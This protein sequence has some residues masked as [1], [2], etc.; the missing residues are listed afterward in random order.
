MIFR[1]HFP[2]SEEKGKKVFGSKNLKSSHLFSFLPPLKEAVASVI[3]TVMSNRISSADVEFFPLDCTSQ[4][5][6]KSKCWFPEDPLSNIFW[7]G[8]QNCEIQKL[9]VSFCPVFCASISETDV[10]LQSQF[11]F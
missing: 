4:E 10:N 7:L 9:I 11:L 2:S 8:V 1:I 3:H 5:G 6:C